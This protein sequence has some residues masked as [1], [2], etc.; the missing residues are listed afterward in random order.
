V[1]KTMKLELGYVERRKWSW[2]NFRLA[3]ADEV[4]AVV[5]ELINYQPLTI[6][7]IFYQLV[8][9]GKRE[10][11]RSKYTDLSRLIV[12]MREDG[13]LPWEIIDDRARRLS[14]KRGYED[15]GE[16]AKQVSDFLGRYQ[17]CL[18][19]GQEWYVET[20]C[21][22]DAL[23]VILEEIAWPYCIRHA[24]C[25][26]FDSRTMLHKFAGRAKAAKS[27]GQKPVLLYFGDFD[28]SGVAGGDATQQTLFESHGLEIEFMRVALSQDQIEAYHLPHAFEAV[29]TKDT[30]AKRFIERYGK[31][32]ACEL[33]ALHP[34]VLRQIT[35][36]AIESYLDMELFKEQQE[37]EREEQRKMVE[38]QQRFLAEAEAVLGGRLN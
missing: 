17:R 23:S 36:N 18:V 6:R 24:T 29:K 11:T 21:E 30:R 19:Q 33:D 32:G 1:I 37:I 8:A 15:A 26:G 20:W 22:K 34:K 16:Y 27:R 9:A 7:Q 12:A 13:M 3:Q 2:T 10:N 14:D 38:L 35:V 31:Y 28:P 5:N 4:T 25:R